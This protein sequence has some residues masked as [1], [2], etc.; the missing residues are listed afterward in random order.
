MK[1]VYTVQAN[2]DEHSDL[3]ILR[4][5]LDEFFESHP[6][7]YRGGRRQFACPLNIK[8]NMLV[9][10]L[11]GKRFS[12][13]TVIED[14]KSHLRF[15]LLQQELGDEEGPRIFDTDGLLNHYG[16]EDVE[17]VLQP[18]QHLLPNEVKA[19]KEKGIFVRSSIDILL[20]LVDSHRSSMVVRVCA[21]HVYASEPCH[22][23]YFLLE[24]LYNLTNAYETIANVIAA[25]EHDTFSTPTSRGYKKAEGVL[26]KSIQLN[27]N[28][29]AEIMY[30]RRFLDDY[31]QGK[32][33]T[34]MLTDGMSVD[35]FTGYMGDHTLITL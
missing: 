27:N 20:D 21:K 18:V 6:T 29:M 2:G 10:D 32:V 9:N 8:L 25:L 7:F 16:I 31:E 17:F 3:T 34:T 33:D 12:V 22:P 11:T 5:G 30:A 1:T 19:L 13:G 26:P 15:A 14:M 24:R 35:E 4:K 28:E 23:K